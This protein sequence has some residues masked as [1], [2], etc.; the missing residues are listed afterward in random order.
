M[1]ISIP[2]PRRPM[3]MRFLARW[4]CPRRRANAARRS[5]V[6]LGRVQAALRVTDEFAPL[7]DLER[8][9]AAEIRQRLVVVEIALAV[10]ADAV[11]DDRAFHVAV[12]GDVD[13][14]VRCV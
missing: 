6:Q 7:A 11:A 3:E 12:A 2:S 5:E 9:A 8:I 10:Q 14:R 1:G 4:A 13:R